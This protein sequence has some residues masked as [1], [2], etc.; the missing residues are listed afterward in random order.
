MRLKVVFYIMIVF[1][2][3]SCSGYFSQDGG[4]NSGSESVNTLRI[5]GSEATLSSDTANDI[6][7]FLFRDT[8]TGNA[9]LFFASDRTN[10]TYKIF[11]SRMESDETFDDPVLMDSTINNPADNIISPAVF[12]S[13]TNIYIS[14]IAYSGGTTNINTYKL[15]SSFN[16]AGTLSSPGV[17]GAR[18]LCPIVTYEYNGL[19]I[20]DGSANVPLYQFSTDETWSLIDTKSVQSNVNSLTGLGI[21]DFMASSADLY[22]LLGLTTGQLSGLTYHADFTYTNHAIN[23]NAGSVTN[24][25]YSIPAYQSAGNNITPFIDVKIG[26]EHSKVYFASDRRGTF[27]LFRYNKETFEKVIK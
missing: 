13:G 20:C 24:Y 23:T 15:D 1:L 4:K 10:S 16:T 9:Y 22:L 3:A 21:V 25:F 7:P 5:T 26:M 18:S 19:A 11:Y 17:A 8:S 14:V 6:C 12:K 27:D 2:L